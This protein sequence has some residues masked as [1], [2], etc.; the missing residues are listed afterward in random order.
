MS[1]ANDR[2]YMGPRCVVCSD[3]ATCRVRKCDGDVYCDECCDHVR[4]VECAELPEAA[5]A[6]D[7]QGQQ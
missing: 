6:R 2:D 1:A 4:G 3:P 5:E 7:A